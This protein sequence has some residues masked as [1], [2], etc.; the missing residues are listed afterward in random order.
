MDGATEVPATDAGLGEPGT[1]S[2]LAGQKRPR[3]YGQELKG[4]PMSDDEGEHHD[5]AYHAPKKQKTVN[6]NGGSDEDLDDGEIVESSP[7][8]SPAGQATEDHST[9]ATTTEVATHEPSEDGEVDTSMSEVQEPSKTDE[10]PSADIS[11]SQPVQHLGW[12]QGVSLGARTSFGK[13]TAQLFPNTSTKAEPSRYA[14]TR[15]RDEWDDNDEG[16]DI[17]D[18]V[19]DD[20]EDEENSPSRPS[21]DN[22]T[23]VPSV[24]PDDPNTK[25]DPTFTVGEYT[26]KFP[27]LHFRMKKST[28][29][30]PSYWDDRLPQWIQAF[31]QQNAFISDRI[32]AEVVLTGFREHLIRPNGPLLNA[33]RKRRNIGRDLAEKTLAKTDLESLVLKTVSSFKEQKGTKGPKAKQSK[34]KKAEAKPTESILKEDNTTREHVAPING[35]K[36]EHE[37]QKGIRLPVTSNGAMRIREVPDG[38]E[39]L[40]QQRRFF[41]DAEDPSKYCLYCSG[42]G[43]RARDCP[44][45]TCQYCGSQ[46][47]SRFGCPLKQRCSK[48]RQLGH[49]GNT[50]DEKLALAV[51]EQGGCA[52]CG[53][54]HAEDQCSE[55]WRSFKL[56]AELHKKVKDIPIF[57]YTCGASGHYGPEC[58]L[59]DRGGKVTGWSTWSQ[60]NRL[61]YVDE[62]SQDIAV[63]W[64]GVEPSQSSHTDFHILGRAKRQTHTHFVSDDD[65]EEDLVH[66]P[67]SRPAPRGEIRISSN[68]GSVGQGSTNTRKPRHRKSRPPTSSGIVQGNN[69]SFQPPLPPGPPPPRSARRERSLAPPPPASLPPR[70]QTFNFSAGD[71]TGD[72]S[73]Q[74]SQGSRGGRGRGGRGRGGHGRGRGNGRGRGRGS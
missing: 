25:P 5:T 62:N 38:D 53:A 29:R 33:T 43:H 40:E 59:P 72:R 60:A 39:E 1:P 50:C 20:D 4:L 58:G 35:S 6:P 55:R 30:S 16:D 26:W 65:S 46:E 2:S 45:L 73:G 69:S 66:A 63:A 51:E 47:H 8:P 28:E 10:T 14:L 74:D 56:V 68:I 48:C 42:V 22:T 18:D 57:C 37:P 64:V 27:N 44:E 11:K 67:V 15:E 52:F 13:P 71:S 41:P 31:L 24:K 3:D 61:R 70:P 54:E 49:N 12:N 32:T 23:Q 19:N 34:S 36:P 9:Q 21:Q 17:K 7:G